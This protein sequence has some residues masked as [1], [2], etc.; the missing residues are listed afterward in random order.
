M[1]NVKLIILIFF[2]LLL[3]I[4][5]CQKDEPSKPQRIVF[6][7]SADIKTINPLY[8]F[9]V[10]EGSIN[11]LLFLSLVKVKWNEHEGDIYTEPF[12][13]E[14]W[15]WS[16]DSTSVTFYLRKD[17]KWSDGE[18][19]TANDVEYSY[20]LYSNP[21]VQSKFY[22]SFE[23]LYL[24]EDFSID[25]E[26]TIEV[27]DSFTIKINFIPGKNIKLVDVVLPI[28]PRHVF[29]EY[30]Y[31]EIPTSEVNF[32]PV[33]CGAYKLKKWERNQMIVLEADTTSFLYSN[34]IIPELV[35]KVIPD[36]NSRLTQLKKGEIDFA[37]QLKPDD[38]EELK[39][40]GNIIIVPVSGREYD[41]V[42]WNHI[43]P[44]IFS[45]TGN[46]EDNKFFA[47]SNVRKALSYAIN[48]EEILKTFL[49]NFGQP[50]V[51]PVSEIFVR[52]FDNE[53]KPINYDPRIAR[54][55]LISEGWID[56][57]KNGIVDKNGIE[58]SF[59]LYIPGGNPIRQYASTI[60][61][62]NLRAV[63]IEVKLETI[64]LNKLIDNLFNK[65]MDAWIAAYYIQIPLEHKMIWSSDLDAAPFNFMSYRNRELD[66]IIEKLDHFN[67]PE[68]DSILQKAFQK[69]IYKDQPVTF[70]YWI[71][72]IVAI[73]SKVKSFE[74]NPL[75]AIQHVWDWKLN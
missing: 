70:L 15:Q 61:K 63:G 18:Q 3:I 44:E 65:N 21:E 26:K 45:S 2:S 9:S 56:N 41:F 35:F 12:L 57:N 58:F 62:N 4:V 16:T 38:V 24:N 42:G 5:S 75:G 22:G 51:T 36:Y 39:N 33:T 54:E 37:E 64:E 47:S 29:N 23:K 28:I 19:L 66:E 20:A 8:A 55:L 49:N 59:T 1:K 71:D 7:I 30:Q 40:T 32:N 11:D 69:I 72:N 46:F 17:V 27:I 43:D 68:Q 67:S 31:N 60:I 25:M 13:A 74:I 34:D 48:R 52:Y 73:N 10:D 6:G 50:A 53:L 14:S